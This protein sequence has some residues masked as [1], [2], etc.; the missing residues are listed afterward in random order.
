MNTKIQTAHILGRVLG[1][2]TEPQIVEHIRSRVNAPA[3]LEDLVVAFAIISA[4][5]VAH[6]EGGPQLLEHIALHYAVEEALE[7]NNP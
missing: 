3:E 4:G 2:D 5:F 6:L 1:G 7:G